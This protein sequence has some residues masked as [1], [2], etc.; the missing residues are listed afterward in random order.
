MLEGGG[1]ANNPRFSLSFWMAKAGLILPTLNL[2]VNL[3]V[4]LGFGELVRKK[5]VKRMFFLR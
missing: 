1:G 4:N 5:K 3:G 2:G